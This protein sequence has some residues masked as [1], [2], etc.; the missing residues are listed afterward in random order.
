MVQRSTEG[1]EGGLDALK[2]I[3][4]R[5]DF[6]ANYLTHSSVTCTSMYGEARQAFRNQGPGPGTRPHQFQPTGGTQK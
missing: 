6:R 2:E 1:A 5:F 3:M 4:A